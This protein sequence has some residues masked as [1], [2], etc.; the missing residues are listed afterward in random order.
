MNYATMVLIVPNNVDK[1]AKTVAIIKELSKNPRESL[2]SLSKRLNLNYLSV[3]RKVHS[4][5]KSGKISFCLQVPAEV[6]G[7]EVA[8]VRVKA[9]NLSA[10]DKFAD[11]CSRVMLTI[12]INSNEL[13]LV[14]RARTKQEALYIAEALRSLI[15]EA[16]EILLEYGTLPQGTYIIVKDNGLNNNEGLDCEPQ[17]DCIRCIKVLMVK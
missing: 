3:W 14:I 16:S 6:L 11:K 10:I 8:L 15:S 17:R 13:L 12:R 9:Q 4:M 2:R 1:D 5:I 7:R